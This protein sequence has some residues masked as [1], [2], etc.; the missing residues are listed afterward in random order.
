MKSIY[1]KGMTIFGKKNKDELL[2][3]PLFERA[4]KGDA[5]A[6]SQLIQDLW[7]DDKTEEL[8]RLILPERPAIFF[9]VPGT[10]R[11]NQVPIAYARFLARQ[12]Q[13]YGSTYLVGDEHIAAL[14]RSMMKSV[15]N[16]NRL[17]SPRLYEPFDQTFFERLRHYAEVSQ[18]ILVED[19]LT[20]GSSVNTFRRFLEHNDVP[21]SC[22][23]GVKG[24]TDICPTESELKK[25]EK[26]GKKAGIE[27][28]DWIALGQELTR[29]ELTALTFQYIGDRYG[30][31]DKALKALMRRQ[32]YYLSELKTKGRYC[33]AHKIEQL[34]V[35][36]DRRENKR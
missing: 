28:I 13:E 23:I 32:L 19:V 25:L 16:G 30:H 5:E 17:M 22:I 20:T 12:T 33:V 34:G 1:K 27:N 11:L 3:N 35:L 18:I 15:K 14:H 8:C 4:K 31:A 7:T 36:I 6:A 29:T 21:V 26:I 2:V 9:S 24:D 10:S